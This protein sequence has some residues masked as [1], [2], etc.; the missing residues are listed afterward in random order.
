MRLPL[1]PKPQI[2]ANEMSNPK[3]RARARRNDWTVEKML[4]VDAIDADEAMLMMAL[5]KGKASKD[6][7]GVITMNVDKN[8]V[9]ATVDC[10]RCDDPVDAG[11]FMILPDRSP[12]HKFPCE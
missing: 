6:D 1:A 7:D 9:E 5:G 11:N 10:E 2:T 8:G 3:N 4:R 12:A